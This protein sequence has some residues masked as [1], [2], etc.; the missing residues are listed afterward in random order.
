MRRKLLVGLTT[1]GLFLAGFG[2]AVLP[3]SAEP[4]HFLLKLANGVSV[5]WTGEPGAAPT[6]ITV[7]GVAIP[8]VSV[9]D[10]GAVA[11]QA[12][13]TVQT[14]QPPPAPAPPA[15]KP[16]SPAPAPSTQPSSSPKP[17]TSSTP[18][19]AKK[20]AQPKSAAPAAQPTSKKPAKTTTKTPV[21]GNQEQQETTGAR[22]AT[23]SRA[24]REGSEKKAK[25][26]KT[27]KPA[28]QTDAATDAK[29]VDAPP[30]HAA[31]PPASNPSFSLAQ[32]GA[33]PVGVPN[34]FID[35]FR[36]PPF[37]LPIYQA[38]GV[39][40]GIRW[41]V[42][43]AINEI[44]TDYGRNLNVSSAGAVGWMQFMP[45]TWDMYGTD[46]NHDGTRDPYNPVDAIFAAARYLKAAGGE[47]DINR[48]IFAYNH[49]DWYVDSV[50]LRARL[51]SGL[52]ADL[53]GSLTGLTQGHFPVH[54][55]AR[56]AKDIDPTKATRRVKKGNAAI[57]VE[58]EQARRGINIYA[59][60]GSPVI[61]VQ[62]GR[63]VKIGNNER[64]GKF[65]MLRDA[66]GN[67]Y[68]YGRLKKLSHTYPV[69]KAQTVSRSQVD[70]ELKLPA[71]PKPTVAASAG[72]QLPTK[73]GAKEAVQAAAQPKVEKERL[74]A[75]P[76]RPRA[77]K[78]GGEDQLFHSGA[79]IP[80]FSTF[81]SFFTE[82]YGLKREDVEL[83]EL[84]VGSKVIAGTILGRI[85]K[86]S[87][88]ATHVLFEVRP[89]GRGAPRVDPKPI[90]DGWK[91]L[92][93]TAIYRAKGKNPFF[94]DDS[95]RPSLGQILLMGKDALSRHVLAN[96]RIDI[97][98]C[99]ARDIRSGAIDR[100]VLATL[101]FLAASGLKPTVTSMKCGHGFY[102][103]SGNVSQHSSGNAV[104]IA[105]VNGIPIIGHQGKGSITDLTIQ[106]LLTLQG[107]MKPDQIISLMT[108]EGADNT[109]ALGDHDD[110]IHVGWKPLYG[111][112]SKAAKQV[113]AVLKPNQWIKLIDRLKEIDNPTV[114]LEPSKYSVKATRPASEAHRGD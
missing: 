54:A 95:D 102:T 6:S 19:G 25:K 29:T 47:A 104:D 69:P 51:I 90:L 84:K 59:K 21:A 35:K 81:K 8:V 63:I 22:R 87:D 43:A 28:K 14:P 89:A 5:P 91:L 57:P 70:K 45:A 33:A 111:T 4:H 13:P 93:S 113:N 79:S 10:L 74:F 78:S 30:A 39:Q 34:F 32:P 73:V 112:N 26:A 52:P 76:Y 15:P 40:Y 97:Y 36:I 96:P 46:A 50:L 20:S 67:T 65:I 105:M 38:A 48:A 55:E 99:G 101:E 31:P 88:K 103:A 3:A 109:L 100:R 2:G 92:E 64:L 24:E 94:G 62:D 7:A 9:Q 85:G 77:Y 16:S 68:T 27:R 82:I 83:R 98:S 11:P 49:A 75:N 56:Y 17:S 18:S 80:G 106:R 86:V 23:K 41:E 114:R 107:T 58:S 72:K 44:E 53:V 42:L 37:L 1:A 61:A 110:H 71:D 66:Y 60:A 12:V 108:F